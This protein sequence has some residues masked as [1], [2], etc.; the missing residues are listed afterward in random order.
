MLVIL[1]NVTLH[2]CSE[3]ILE[4]KKRALL[5]KEAM[6]QEHVRRAE[7]E[8]KQREA[9]RNQAKARRIV[10]AQ[11]AQQRADLDLQQKTAYFKVC[12]FC[13]ETTAGQLLRLQRSGKAAGD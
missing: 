3:R 6:E 13:C 4:Q 9:V 12:H 5:T 1:T 2:P 7:E 10:D 8:R 11:R